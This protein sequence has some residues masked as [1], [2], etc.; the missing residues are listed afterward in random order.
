MID[1]CPGQ[2]NIVR[3][4]QDVEFKCSKCGKIVEVWPPA[5][6]VK[7][8]NCGTW[9]SRGESC[10]DWCPGGEEMVKQC[11]GEEKYKEWKKSKAMAECCHHNCIEELRSDHE[12]ILAELDKLEA[13]PAGYAKE[14][15]KFTEEFAEPHHHKEEEV[16]FPALEKKGIPNEGGPIGMML[17]EH[18]MKRG[19]VKELAAGKIEAAMK[20][21]SL[22]RDHINKE[23][24]ILYPMA[25]Q[26]LT[27]EE[28]AEMGH[29]CEKL[30]DKK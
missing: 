5:L 4:P 14:F 26:V 22:L 16:L 27:E 25:E 24:N 23:N 28:L 10:A 3:G 6:G 7:C 13:D 2:S 18:E 12:K 20:I 11:L 17:M 15:L 29:R 21:V 8:P 19:Y 9:V 1:K 30:K